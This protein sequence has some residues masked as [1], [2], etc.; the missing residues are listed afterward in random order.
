M[1]ASLEDD[2]APPALV[3]VAAMPSDPSSSMEEQQTLRVPITLVTGMPPY[4]Q[5]LHGHTNS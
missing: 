5:N 1:A 3:D 4:A 2:D